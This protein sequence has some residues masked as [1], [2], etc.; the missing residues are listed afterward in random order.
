MLVVNAM[1]GMSS[2]IGAYS[3]SAADRSDTNGFVPTAE[4]RLE[5]SVKRKRAVE[6][7]FMLYNL[8][9]YSL[10][11]SRKFSENKFS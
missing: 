4:Q 9:Y 8:K 2:T 7:R 3:R 5:Q 10:S 6:N 11:I 1:S